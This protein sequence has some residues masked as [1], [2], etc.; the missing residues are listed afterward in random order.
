MRAV[1]VLMMALAP[2]VAI[3][4][5]APQAASACERLASLSLPNT[6]I[7]LAQVVNA[8]AFTAPANPAATRRRRLVG[9]GGHARSCSRRARESDGQHRGPRPRVQ[10]RARHPAVQRASSVLP[11][12]GDAEA[13]G[14]L[15]H[16]HGNVDADRRLERP[17][18]R[19][20]PQ[21]PRRRHQLQRDG[22]R[23]DRR[24]RRRQHR[25]RASGR[26]HRLDAGSG[27]G[28]RLR[29]PRHARDDGRRE[30]ARPP[31]TTAP[32]RSTRT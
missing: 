7:T 10:R 16:S 18:P 32:L 2:G 9:P 23:P 13:V 12:G 27:Q 3:A 29:R 6:A 15:R 17:L 8:G 5:R 11:R 14:L 28:D 20:E 22:R 26:R 30:G 25:H 24:L 19:H 1:L 4:Q 31:P 21:R